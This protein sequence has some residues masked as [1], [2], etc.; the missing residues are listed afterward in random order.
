VT[1]ERNQQ[2]KSSD[3]DTTQNNNSFSQIL[4]REVEEQRTDSINCRTVTYGMDMRL[5][6]F[7]YRAREYHY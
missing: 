1:R 3:R 6:H 2:E 7:D 4:Q 5:H